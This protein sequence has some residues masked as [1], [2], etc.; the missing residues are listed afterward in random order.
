M[1][2]LAKVLSFLALVTMILN[3]CGQ[4]E[5]ASQSTTDDAKDETLK[6]YTTLYPLQ[7]FTEQIGA[8]YVEVESILPAGADA[9]T[10]EPTS[11]TIVDIAEA[12][13][14]VFHTDE[15]ETYAATIKEAL[16]KDIPTLEAA[17]GIAM[18]E[19]IHGE[20][21][22][23]DGH[24]HATGEEHDHSEEESAEEEHRHN[25]GDQ[26]P[27]VWLDP[28]RSIAMAE[29]IKDMLI[30]LKPKA[31]EEL[32]TNFA[33]LK[34]RLEKLDEKFHS[35]LEAQARNEILVTHAAYGY[36]EEAYGIEQI[37]ITGLSPSNEPSQ[38]QI[39]NIIDVVKDH[40]I[41]YLLFEQNVEP[42][43]AKIIQNEAG[44]ES[45]DIHNLEVLTEEDI[46]NKEDYF[47]IME[48]NL[49][50]LVKALE[51]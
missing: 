50:V 2:N 32:E 36:W 51:E 28:I 48:K 33:D 42:N 35:Q 22:T 11:K 19:H 13:A 39:E 18:L 16:D 21:A 1:K 31:K 40:G 44:L 17:K 10:Y 6:I 27:H 20:E 47:S 7:Y 14:F 4:D 5:E 29:N 23:E 25:H 9:H 38:K 37:A 49:A 3:A 41:Q 8:S 34:E 26:D 24:D 15:M 45:L 12:D 30:E 46:E 43:V